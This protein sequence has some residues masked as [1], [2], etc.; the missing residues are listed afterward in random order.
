MG[1]LLDEWM[2]PFKILPP[3]A[4]PETRRTG[5]FEG[6]ASLTKCCLLIT[7]ISLLPRGATFGAGL[8]ARSSP[9]GQGALRALFQPWSPVLCGQLGGKDCGAL[10]HAV[11]F[12]W[13]GFHSHSSAP[14][15]LQHQS[16][17]SPSAPSHQRCHPD[18]SASTSIGS[19]N[20]HLLP[21]QTSP[22]P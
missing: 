10:I 11:V 6:A 4:L 8:P 7:C 12:P 13:K 22:P 21:A 20:V 9:A 18:T 5:E 3:A 1:T 15:Q 2:R 14:L 19:C 17:R 16:A